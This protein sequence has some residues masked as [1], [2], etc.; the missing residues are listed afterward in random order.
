MASYL[1]ASRIKNVIATPIIDI[2]E[3]VMLV[4]SNALDGPLSKV[5]K[6]IMY[7]LSTSFIINYIQDNYENP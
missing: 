2:I 3:H 5:I 1:N 7:E 4:M 6:T